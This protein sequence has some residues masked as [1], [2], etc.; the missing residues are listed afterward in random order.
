MKKLLYAVLS[1]AA[2]AGTLVSCSD[3]DDTTTYYKLSVSLE[4]PEGV[5]A[6]DFTSASVVVINSQTGR[7]YSDNEIK[8][9]YSF[10][11]PGGTYSVTAALRVNDGGSVVSYSASKSVPVYEDTPV[12]LELTKSVSGGLIFKE[13]YYNMVKPN[14]KMP[15]MRDQFFEIYNNSDEVLYLDNCIL[16]FLEG[17]QGKLPTAW[18][19]NGEIMKEYALGYYT[20]AFVSQ[21]GK[22]YPLEPGKSVVIAGQAQ[23]HIAET[24]KMY[25]PNDGAMISPVNLFNADYEVFL[26]DYKPAVSSVSWRVR[27]VNCPRLGRKT[28]RL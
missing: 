22:D 18:Q 27:R 6:A 5:S 26:G 4:M 1:L 23:N 8:S 17:S 16:G 15:Y 25:E 11:L 2:F 28:A 13:V 12:T 7:E 21:T 20:V 10:E 24:E 19:E 14:G 3:N 9:D